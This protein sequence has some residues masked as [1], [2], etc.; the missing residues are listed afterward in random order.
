M[1]WEESERWFATFVVTGLPN[2]G[3][4]IP[5]LIKFLEMSAE[6]RE[7]SSWEKQVLGFARHYRNSA[8]PDGLPLDPQRN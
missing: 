7:L 6:R 1:T 3:V 4:A 5:D 8:G 2:D